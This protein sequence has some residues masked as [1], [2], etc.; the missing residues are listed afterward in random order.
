MKRILIVDD[1]PF[2]RQVIEDVLTEE[3]YEVLV[4]SSGRTMLQVLET[5]Q[6]NLILLDVMMPD[7]DG[8]DALEAMQSQPHLRDIPVV[9]ISSGAADHR[10][11]GISVP[12]LTKPFDI[13][14]LMSV[15]V[16]AV[17]PAQESDD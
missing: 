1:E 17:G 14:Q 9:I 11:K 3:G 13:D 10:L 15:V 6:P 16:D 2:I 5:Q 7:G 12:T 4:A 8:R